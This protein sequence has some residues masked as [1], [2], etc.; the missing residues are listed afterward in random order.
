MPFEQEKEDRILNAATELFAHYGFKKTS[1][2]QIANKA[3]VGKG[4][5]YLICESKEDLLYRVVHREIR[6]WVAGLSKQVDP[7]VPADQLLITCS[8]EAHRYLEE[9][10]LVRDLLLGNYEEMLP[11]WVDRLSD[12]RAIGRTHTVE[13][14]RI[15]INQGRFRTDLPV[16]KLAKILQDMQV[17]GLVLAYREQRTL[18]EQLDMGNTCLDVILRG[19]LRR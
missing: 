18:E 9:R 12:L 16:D 2:D 13:I 19:L 4:T 7:R 1:I 15:G 14:L 10:P 8:F 6:A 11:M 17:M 3:G 5:V